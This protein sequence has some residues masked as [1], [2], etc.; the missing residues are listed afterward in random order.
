MRDLGSAIAKAVTSC[1]QPGSVDLVCHWA[2][3]VSPPK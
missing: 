2:P 1:L 3:S